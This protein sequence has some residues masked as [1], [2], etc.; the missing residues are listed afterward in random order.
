V[1]TTTT[2]T[3]STPT[4]EQ[5]TVTTVVETHPDEHT[6]ETITKQA[7]FSG[8]IVPVAENEPEN[9]E[10]TNT[11]VPSTSEESVEEKT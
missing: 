9:T 10:G 3:I 6:A 11:V 8:Y 1:T 7:T 5:T 4:S 2:K